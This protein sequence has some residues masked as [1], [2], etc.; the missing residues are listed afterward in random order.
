MASNVQVARSQNLNETGVDPSGAVSRTP[1]ELVKI[2]TTAA[3]ADEW[4]GRVRLRA[5]RRWYERLYF[6]PDY[7]LWLIAWLPGQSTGFH[8]HGTSSG[9]FVVTTGFLEEHRPSGRT[10]IVRPGKP[11][12]F[13]PK[14]AHDV[15]NASL[16]PA[17][18]IHAYS[19][20]L[21]EMNEYEFEG[22]RLIRR[23]DAS[24]GAGT[25]DPRSHA[26]VSREPENRIDVSRVD[27]LLA[28]MQARL[29]RLSPQDAFEAVTTGNA[30]L[31][32][33]R[34][35]QQR[36]SEGS[37]PGALV[38]ERNV[39]EWRFDPTS[40]ARL[41]I[42]QGDGLQVIVFCSQGYA[43]SLAASGLLF[44]RRFPDRDRNS[45]EFLKEKLRQNVTTKDEEA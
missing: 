25:D 21:T 19:P 27:Q 5:D 42:A 22:G 31:V 23:D 15:R 39:L 26:P 20:P 44:F 35:A 43:S 11:R 38:V 14:Y 30:V 29:R 16:A 7:D 10:R 41:P 28:A 36:A 8:H 13:G 37:I 2:V 45:T 6:G 34:P 12:A 32:D 33:I 24:Q 9:A 17:I 4:V 3:A 18:S 40:A 1:A